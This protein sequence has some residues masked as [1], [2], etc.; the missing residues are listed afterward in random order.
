MSRAP[1][2][3]R[4]VLVSGSVDLRRPEAMPAGYL[5]PKPASGNYWR[6]VPLVDLSLESEKGAA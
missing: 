3:R 5:D 1:Y 2:R 4:P 6:A